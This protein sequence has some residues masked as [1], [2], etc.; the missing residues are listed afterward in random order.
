M[1]YLCISVILFL[2]LASY[3]I[4]QNTSEYLTT[5]G[6][7][8][9]QGATTISYDGK[10]TTV[11]MLR[12]S[13]QVKNNSKVPML[14]AKHVR[15]NRTVEFLSP[16]GAVVDKSSNATSSIEELLGRVRFP[17]FLERRSDPVPRFLAS[18]S[19]DATPS[20]FRFTVVP[21]DGYYEFIDTFYLETGYEVAGENGSQMDRLEQDRLKNRGNLTGAFIKLN[22]KVA[23]SKH[24]YLR[25]E[26]RISPNGIVKDSNFFSVLQERWNRIGTLP[27]N[28]EDYVIRSEPI[29]NVLESAP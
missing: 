9:D 5:T 13:L 3:A 26:Y 7:I 21:P 12:I 14:V 8:I 18:I 2:A 20:E 19:G 6:T 28:G 29:V 24:S 25:V 4:C 1:N 22:S 11:F 23:R 17:Q 15:G 27:L 10:R 16:S